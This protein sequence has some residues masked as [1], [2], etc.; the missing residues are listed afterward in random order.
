METRECEYCRYAQIELAQIGET[1]NGTP[2]LR[3]TCPVCGNIETVKTF[4]SGGQKYQ[5][6]MNN[7]DC[8]DNGIP[9]VP[10]GADVCEAQDARMAEYER[11][12]KKN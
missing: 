6:I 5:S 8:E 9:T 4:V 3:G 7:D 12:N 2:V 10:R 1:N 11:A